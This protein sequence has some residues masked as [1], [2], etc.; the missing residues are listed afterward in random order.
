MDDSKSKKLNRLAKVQGHLKK[1][2]ENELA[3]TTRERNEIAEKI[4]ALSGYLTSLDPMHQQMLKH[5]ATRHGKLMSRDV[6]LESIEKAQEQQ[7]LKET[8]KGERLED[9]RDAAR[10][11]E[12]RV[13][14][15]NSVYELIDLHMSLKDSSLQQG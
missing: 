14:E 2:A 3:I 7:V 9:K 5:Y 10:A 12:L 8:K 11:D 15:D 13:R 4:D 6:R 1:M